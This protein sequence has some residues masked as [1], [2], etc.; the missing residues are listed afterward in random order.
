MIVGRDIECKRLSSAMKDRQSHF[1]ALY[2]RR[3]V[4]K[5][6][7]VKNYFQHQFAFYCTGLLKGNKKQQLTN[8]INALQSYFP[9][10]DPSVVI[11]NWYEAFNAL[12]KALSKQKSAGKKVIF[13]DEMP[14]MDTNGSDF[15]LG[16]EYFWNSWAS[17]RKDVLLIVCGSA[18]TW[19]VG[20]LFNDTGGL[21]NRITIKMRIDPF[22]L[23]ECASFF[24]A[25]GLHYS[26]VQ[27]I[28]AYM[29]VGGIPFYLEQFQKGLSPVQNIDALFF[30]RKALFADEYDLLFKSLFKNHSSYVAVI[31][32][33]SKKNKG[34][35]RAGIAQH[36][37]L[38]DGGSLTKILTQLEQSNFIRKYRS[39]HK[40]T[41]DTLY[42][43][44]DPFCLFYNNFSPS[45]NED[46]YWIQNYG[47]P[48][49]YNWSGYAFEVVCLNHI[50]EIKV[51]LGISGIQSQTYT[52]QNPNAQID[53]LIDRADKVI[54]M[55][56]IKYSQGPYTI[57]KK[58]EK[59]LRN[60]AQQ[61]AQFGSGKKAIWPVMISPYGLANSPYNHFFVNVLGSDIFMP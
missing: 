50:E 23:Q 27:C 33:I 16:L 22:T 26:P 59:E 47:T 17:A 44:I 19:M 31:E 52:W 7:L 38:A 36:S 40:K 15:I 30:G 1:I 13:L 53:L 11:T 42:Q 48:K 20:K 46:G 6:Y 61:L 32:A 55:V 54:N 37:G 14:W 45:L 29:A 5:T 18:T 28:E 3:R 2:G 34:L 43:L 60:K 8:F 25:K 51:A 49:F 57:T 39:M 41:K 35:D 56:E 9:G 10:F 24:Q 21:Y 4:G 12:S 58:Y